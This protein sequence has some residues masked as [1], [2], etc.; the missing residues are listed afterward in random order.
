MRSRQGA[1][2]IITGPLPPQVC[3]TP[4]A[5]AGL[6][7]NIF[8]VLPGNHAVATRNNAQ[9]AQQGLAPCSYYIRHDEPH[10]GQTIPMQVSQANHTVRH[11]TDTRIKPRHVPGSDPGLG[12]NAHTVWTPSSV[13]H[14]G[15]AMTN[16]LQLQPR[17]GR[18]VSHE[19]SIL[20]GTRSET[21]LQSKR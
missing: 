11:H 13:Q 20:R 18:G 21:Q 8:T 7:H 1:C 3:H 4:D 2:V 14:A 16:P 17:R 15:V 10:M 9:P 19:V 6:K 5:S 12:R